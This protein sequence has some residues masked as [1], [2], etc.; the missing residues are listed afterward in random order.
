MKWLFDWND[1]TNPQRAELVF[2]NRNRE[3]GAYQLRRKYEKRVI[4]ALLIAIGAVAL[5]VA[6]PII[7]NLI[8]KANF[9]NNTKVIEDVTLMEPP[10]IDKSTPPPPPV[11]P[12]PPVQQTIKFTPPKV[13]KDEEVQ[14]PPPTQE[15]V[16]EVQVSTETHEGDKNAVE[17]PPETPAGDDEGKIFTIV[18]EMPSFPGG[19]EKML[20]YVAK[21]IKYPP[22]ARENGIQGRVYVNFYIDKDGKV[23]NAKVVRGIGGGCDEEALRVV[24]T[25]PTWKPGKQNGRAVN[26]NYNLPINFTLK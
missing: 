8:S 9:G 16:K 18:E 2:A 15:E 17:L 6:I 5:A 14:E 4:N 11:I 24:K 10:P 25:M 12:P 7:V 13:V 20:E 22:V 23:Q 1:A 26:V 21:N 19:E 3:Y